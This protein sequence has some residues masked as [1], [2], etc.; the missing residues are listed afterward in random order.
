MEKG[1][2][3]ASPD[4]TNAPVDAIG[5]GSMTAD[6]TIAPGD[7]APPVGASVWE[8][9]VFA[10]LTE[11]VRQEQELLEEYVHAARESESKALGYLI[12]LLIDDERRHHRMFIQLAQ[13][14]KTDAEMRPEDPVVP[15]LDFHKENRAEVLEITG[16]LLDREESDLRELK[17]LHRELKEVKDTTLWD[18]LVELMERDTDKHIAILRFSRDHAKHPPF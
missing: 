4:G 10:H 1:G 15:R 11:H 18:L 9:E 5:A 16:R 12:N 13:S 3:G 6:A 8:R 14:L 2:N 7:L 17:R